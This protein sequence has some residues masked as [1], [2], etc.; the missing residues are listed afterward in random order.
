[1]SVS[2][3]IRCCPV[4]AQNAGEPGGV[5]LIRFSTRGQGV[6]DARSAPVSYWMVLAGF[7]MRGPREM[8]RLLREL[9]LVDG[10]LLEVLDGGETAEG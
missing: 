2:Y 8:V 3:L 4:A 1:M 7:N 10:P 5:G 6:V 9:W